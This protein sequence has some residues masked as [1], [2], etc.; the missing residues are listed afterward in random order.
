M[1]DT[2]QQKVKD[3]IHFLISNRNK[4]ATNQGLILDRF[5][6]VLYDEDAATAIANDLTV[7]TQDKHFSDI[8]GLKVVNI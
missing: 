5:T 1:T 6:G 4:S 3:C 2:I 7:F 8:D